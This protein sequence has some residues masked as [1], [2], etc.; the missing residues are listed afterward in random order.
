MR[1][2]QDDGA[3]AA[4]PGSA[5]RPVA[6]ALA[7]LWRLGP[8]ADAAGPGTVVF[9][10]A[11]E[12][13]ELVAAVR[14]GSAAG[15]VVIAAEP[16][17]AAGPMPERRLR[18]GVAR[19]ARRARV[20][21]DFVVFAA[22]RPVVRT[23]VGN[24]AVLLD[25]R[26]LAVGG[27]L[28][29]RWGYLGVLWA[30]APIED[31][32]VDALDRPLLKLRPLGSVR[33][34]D[35]PG[36]AQMQLE[37]RAK[38]DEFATKRMRGLLAVYRDAGALLSVAI[39]AR[40]LRDGEPVPIEQVWPEGIAALRDG[41]AAGVFDPV[42]H[43]WLH[44]DTEL[45][46]E[47]TIEAR[48]FLRLSEEEAGRR[49][50]AALEWQREHLGEPSTFVAPA[51]GY[52]EGALRALAKRSLPAWHRAAAE[53]LLVDGNPRE[54]LIGAGSPI[55]G[56]FKLDYGSLQRLAASGIPPTPVLHGGLLDDRLAARIVRDALVYARLW[57]KRDAARLPAIQGIRWVGAGELAERYR[58]HG[59]SEVR[60]G[61]AI[62]PA[63]AEAVL[64]GPDGSRAVQG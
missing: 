14:G 27:D 41:V 7:W 32:L 16:G 56:V 3:L 59:E 13:A 10:D 50:D 37:D 38:T 58:A 47:G 29:G 25:D 26:V 60:D 42:C 30:L 15:A 39:P 36:T 46:A 62:L 43:G 6:E 48:E 31:L 53:P 63:G 1:A 52:S 49:I 5:A 34:D 64:R 2:V 22:G 61:R 18:R 19:F 57:R 45:R 40:A 54:T 21:D 4:A 12:A 9:G 24:H 8:V 33:I 17:T 51:W 11:D 55:G 44:Y 35:V 20:H 28:A 23:R